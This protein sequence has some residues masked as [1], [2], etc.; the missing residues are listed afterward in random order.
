MIPRQHR[1][2]ILAGVFLALLLSGCDNGDLTGP[3]GEDWIFEPVVA[4]QELGLHSAVAVAGDGTVHLAWHDPRRHKLH[5]AHR[6]APRQWQDTLVDSAGWVGAHVAIH[7]DAADQVHLAYHDG[8]FFQLRYALFDGTAWSVERLTPST[9][10][11]AEG[12]EAVIFRERPDGLH[13]VEMSSAV[14]SADGT[15]RIR[16]WIRSGGAWVLQSTY[17][18]SYLRPYLGFAWGDGGPALGV[19]SRDSHGGVG[20]RASFSVRLLTASS[21]AGPWQ[22]WSVVR[23]TNNASALDYGERAV[24]VGFDAAG[25]RHLLYLD[26]SGE[27]RD[28]AG[29]TV[30]SGVRN[31][32]VHLRSGPGGDLYAAYA[33]NRHL[34]VARYGPGSGWQKVSRFGGFDQQGRY[35][36]LV[37][38]TGVFHVSFYAGGAQQLWYGRGEATP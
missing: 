2:V 37:D 21:G 4:G 36:F 8:W 23:V 32:L 22:E 11:M 14:R 38:E 13:L 9:L 1:N 12:G 26:R 6:I 30:D 35:D 17:S 16:Y 25:N 20:P 3:G 31:T 27:L 24:A 19:L 18:V 10:P 28:S 29:G 33:R 5:L 34:I 7:I 15:G